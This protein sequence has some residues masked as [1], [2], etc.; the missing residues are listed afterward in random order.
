VPREDCQD[1]C[2]I[3]ERLD[4]IAEVDTLD[5]SS[6]MALAWWLRLDVVDRYVQRSLIRYRRGAIVVRCWRGSYQVL[7]ACYQR[8][9]RSA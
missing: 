5:G 3:G 8:L 4:A 9:L 7:S 6:L 1:R 2:G